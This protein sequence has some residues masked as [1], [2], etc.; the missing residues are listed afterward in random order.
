MT[1][2][3]EVLA[4]LAD[5]RR[6][7]PELAGT[8]LAS[9]DGLL[10][11]HDVPHLEPDGISALAAAHFALAQRFADAVSHGDLRETVIE[12]GQGYLTTYA[13]GPH[14]V[15]AVVSRQE[16]NLA[17]VHLEARRTTAKISD[18]IAVNPPESPASP[19]PVPASSA[20]APP[21]LA[22]RTPM[23]TLPQHVVTHRGTWPAPKQR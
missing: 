14:A 8:V 16:A 11:A 20:E 21:P 9:T 1:A 10:L 12:C 6:R 4:E 2:H 15:L 7:V 13:V 3:P 22:R 5:L 19:P 18:A 23:A 17:R